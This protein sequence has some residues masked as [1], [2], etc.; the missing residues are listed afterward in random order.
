M[1]DLYDL[2]EICKKCDVIECKV[3]EG[4][5]GLLCAASMVLDSVMEAIEEGLNN[6]VKYL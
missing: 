5:N 4:E 1:T 6:A 3:H 2:D